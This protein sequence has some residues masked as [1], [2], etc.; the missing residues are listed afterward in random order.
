MVTDDLPWAAYTCSFT[1]GHQ[2][3][4]STTGHAR[5]RGF[6]AAFGVN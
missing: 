5:Q 6:Q 2:L 4:L 1:N 3:A